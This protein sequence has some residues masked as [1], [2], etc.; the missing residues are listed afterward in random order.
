VAEA[1]RLGVHA[2]RPSDHHGVPVRQ[3]QALH[4]RE[5][6]LEAREQQ[7]GRA[8]QLKRERGVEHVR[9]RHAEV[10]PAPGR[11]DRGADVLDE[12]GDV[13]LRHLLELGD[14]PRIEGR[15]LAHGAGVVLGD[16]PEAR[17]RLDGEDLD[18]EPVGQ[19][20]L[21]GPHGGH[22]GQRVPGDHARP[23]PGKVG[24]RTNVPRRGRLT[25]AGPPPGR[26]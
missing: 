25:G 24:A 26:P 19:P 9:R 11:P 8:A 4:D 16:P 17:P 1:R 12:R 21:V 6:A 18:L 14:A 22:L 23:S 5:Q 10:H 15:A 2:V 3:R 7:I 13:V 20:R